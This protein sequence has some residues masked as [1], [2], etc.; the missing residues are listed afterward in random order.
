MN[1]EPS[2]RKSKRK[3]LA[4]VLVFCLLSAA[5]LVLIGPPMV[6]F[7]KNPQQV[8]DWVEQKGAWAQIGFIGMVAVQVIIALI[9]GEPLEIAAGY[10]FGAVEGTLL[11]LVGIALGSSIVFWFVR[12]LGMKA[13]QPFFSREE[14]ENLPL[15]R[16]QHRLEVFAF[17]LFFIPGTP[18]DVMTWAVGLTPIK[19][20]HWLFIC[21]VARLPS[22]VTSTVGGA[23][24]GT[25]DYLMAVYVFAA[26]LCISLAG[27]F[28]Y[29]R[30]EK[31]HARKAEQNDAQI[32]HTDTDVHNKMH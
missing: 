19:F 4:A 32:S 25:Q 29:Q 6:E 13:V 20:S 8:R 17:L 26:T 28:V 3:S 24:L 31:K 9:P 15:L 16:N 7:F 2:T 21:F 18:K 1:Q 10:A 5:A 30:I 27:L 22:V 11:C 14:I 12:I 23:A